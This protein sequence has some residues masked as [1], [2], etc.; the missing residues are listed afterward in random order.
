MWWLIALAIIIGAI[1]VFRN[2]CKKRWSNNSYDMIE[3]ENEMD[4][5]YDLI[6]G[7]KGHLA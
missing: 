2:G 1:T 4:K 3:K 6:Y 7:N 5:G